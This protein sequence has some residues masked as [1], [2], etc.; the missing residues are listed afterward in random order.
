MAVYRKTV[1]LI[2]NALFEVRQ[3]EVE[4][5]FSSR[6]VLSCLPFLKAG[7]EIELEAKLDLANKKLDAA[8]AQALFEDEDMAYLKGVLLEWK[9][10]VRGSQEAIMILQEYM[11][12]K[13]FGL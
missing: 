3:L 4:K 2:A 7:S 9:T 1:Q 10:G 11:S 13:E 5:K 12:R 6:R 8:V